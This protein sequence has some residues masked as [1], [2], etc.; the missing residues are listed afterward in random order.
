MKTLY[1]L[2]DIE[3]N[4]LSLQQ[5]IQD[6]TQTLTNDEKVLAAQA[7]V[8]NAEGKLPPLNK[9]SR[10][11]EDT[12]DAT[13]AKAKEAE[14]RLYSGDLKN[15]KE[16]R[17]LQTELAMLK[18]KQNELEESM[19]VVM[20]NVETAEATL[21]QAQ[22]HLT[23]ITKTHQQKNDALVAE[24]A[25]KQDNIDEL[26]T[27]GDSLRAKVDAKDMQLYEQ[28]KGRTRGLPIAK[29]HNDGTCGKCGVQ[30]NRTT[31][32]DIRRGNPAQ[33]DNCKRILIFL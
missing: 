17:E 13:A 7:A 10:E 3:Q 5:Q 16:L 12:I 2:Q 8:T 4:I 6:I 25:R 29:M 28:L 15:P 30:Q 31:E 14:E 20:E 19:F 1:K 32:T 11:L 21:Q 26:E 33:C 9:H 23:N 24:R 27:Q 18:A 22:T